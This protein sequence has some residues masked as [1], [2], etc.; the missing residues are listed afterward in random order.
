MEHC[1]D[2][3]LAALAEFMQDSEDW[4]DLQAVE[5]E[6]CGALSEMFEKEVRHDYVTENEDNSRS[7]INI[8]EDSPEP[9]D[10]KHLQR[11]DSSSDDEDSDF[12]ICRKKG[13]KSRPSISLDRR[14][15]GY[16][17]RSSANHSSTS[18]VSGFH[19][20]FL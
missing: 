15:T 10:Q 1:G 12:G 13:R 2:D 9:K 6:A 14:S 17:T 7:Y 3:Y 5:T 11:V 18:T 19:Q 16:S 4:D 20:Y 8:I